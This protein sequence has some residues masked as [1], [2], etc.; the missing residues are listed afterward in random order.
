M[1]E[2][3]PEAPKERTLQDV[4]NEYAQL[5]NKA[6][7]ISYS[8]DVYTR[9]LKIVHDRMRDLNFESVALKAKEEQKAAA[10]KVK[11][12]E[13]EQAREQANKVAVAQP[14]PL[15]QAAEKKTRKLKEVKANA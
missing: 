7:Q 9:D 15:P 4:Y 3:K 1:S 14:E 2:Q 8:I 13:A 10:E 6:G 12:A 5:S 11:A